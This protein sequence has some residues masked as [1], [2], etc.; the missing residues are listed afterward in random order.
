[1]NYISSN[2]IRRIDY[3][4]GYLKK[5]E[6]DNRFSVYNR[7]IEDIEKIKLLYDTLNNKLNNN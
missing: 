3:V 6:I 5:L 7:T 4:K 2:I 1:M